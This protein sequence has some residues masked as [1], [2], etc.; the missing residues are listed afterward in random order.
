MII[1]CSFSY[2]CISFFLLQYNTVEKCI[3]CNGIILPKS[4]Y[5]Q[6]RHPAALFFWKRHLSLSP[7]QTNKETDEK[8][9]STFQEETPVSIKNRLIIVSI[10]ALLGGAFFY[11]MDQ[12]KQ[13]GMRKNY[14]VFC[15]TML[16]DTGHLF[17]R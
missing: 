4:I 13:T 9:E 7:S 17:E 5:I 16:Y 14:W 6:A 15:Y 11:F 12:R 2:F 8:N 10:F 3:Q 1:L